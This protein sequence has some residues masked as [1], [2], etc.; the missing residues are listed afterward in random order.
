MAYMYMLRCVDESIYTGST[1]SLKKRMSEHYAGLGAEYT[2]RRMPVRLIYYEEYESIGDAYRREKKV[3]GWL[4][5]RKEH[6]ISTGPGVRVTSD[7]EL[8]FPG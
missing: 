3:Q 6:L 7:D 2:S 5:S 4:K 8:W 1:W